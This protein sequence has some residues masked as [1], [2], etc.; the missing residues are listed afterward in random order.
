M[1]LASF[2]EL[3]KWLTGHAHPEDTKAPEFHDIHD[4]GRVLALKLDILCD[5]AHSDGS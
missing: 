4:L 2:A 3:A 5:R 1:N